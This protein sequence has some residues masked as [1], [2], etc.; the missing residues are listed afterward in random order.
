MPLLLTVSTALGVIVLVAVLTDLVVTTLVPSGGAGPL[1]TRLSGLLWR[2]ALVLHRRRGAH[3]ALR[4]AG[5]LIVISI[6]VLWLVGLVAGWALVFG[7]EGALVV[8]EGGDATPAFGKVYF[9]AATV[10]GRGA[11]DFSPGADV[12]QVLEQIAA[13]TGVALVGLGIAY[14]IPIVNAVVQKREVASYI[15]SLGATPDEILVRAWDGESFGSLHLHF[16]ALTP[17]LNRLAQN[18]LAYP[19]LHYFHSGERFTALGPSIVV[20]DETLSLAEEAL[21]PEARLDPS[22]VRPCRAAVDGFLRSLTSVAV[23]SRAEPLPPPT[24]SAYR[25]EDL[26]LRSDDEIRERYEA[27]HDRRCLL[28]GFLEHDGWTTDETRSFEP[29][30]WERSGGGPEG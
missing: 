18:H 24:I 14:V 3:R 1:S 15:G 9:A 16:V 8:S 27:L 12:W 13:G 29:P 28:A 10:L 6:V 5:P 4:A 17:L 26:P 22:S 30:A 19:V 11:T 20:L 25:D 2:T 7:R 23:V 21:L